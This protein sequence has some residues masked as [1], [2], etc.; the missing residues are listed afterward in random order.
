[1]GVSFGR[2]VANPAISSNGA[3]LANAGGDAA[4]GV[5][6]G[7]WQGALAT[8]NGAATTGSTH[9]INSIDPTSASQFASLG[10]SLVNATYTYKGGPA[11]TDQL[12]TQGKINSLSVGVNFST[13]SIT[14]Y[15]VNASIPANAAVGATTWN[16]SGSGTIS[17]FTG[18]SGIA[19]IGTCY[20]CTPGKGDPAA[21]GSANGA[22]VGSAA[23]KMITS[24]G[25]T[26]ASQAISGV[27]YLS[28]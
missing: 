6:W 18:A 5:N 21:Q 17:Q 8:V 4:F 1:M 24:F 7:S 16:A 13:Q 20:G 22:F 3:T 26:A 2:S 10:S 12:G 15:T 27:G 9:F 14:N 23:Q 19:L 25:L 11:P 28:R